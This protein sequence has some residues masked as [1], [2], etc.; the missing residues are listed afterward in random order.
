MA[1]GVLLAVVALAPPARAEGSALRPALR[2][3]LTEDPVS[4]PGNAVIGRDPEDADETRLRGTLAE[5]ITSTAVSVGTAVGYTSNAGPSLERAASAVTSS[6]AEIAHAFQRDG[7]KVS[8]GA[9]YSD[10]R[11]LD[12]AD[13]NEQQ[14]KVTAAYAGKT[15]FGGE[16]TAAAGAERLLD[17]EENVVK[18][19][20]SLGYEWAPALLTP[21][22]QGSIA[23]L[24]YGAIAGEFLEFG[25]QNDRD[26]LTGSV[27]VGLKHAVSSDLTVKAGLGADAKRYDMAVDDFGLRRDNTSVF[28]FLAASYAK[29]GASADLLYAPVFR[30]YRERE[31]APLVAHT[32]AARG[33]MQIAP[34]WKVFAAARAGLEETDFFF[35]KTVRESVVSIG[36]IVTTASGASGGLEVSYTINDY[37][38]L[39]RIDHKI[40]AVVRTKIPLGGNFLLTGEGR[41]LTFR[42]TFADVETDMVMGLVGVVY[43]FSR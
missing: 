22:V 41:Y 4:R 37:V 23:H 12:R 39:P 9:A 42:S 11:Y 27:Q 21:F 34:A 7:N 31:F 36:G 14:V 8:L 32:L 15:G 18:V 26:R 13:V 19:G 3:T 1:S 40:E 29:G 10:R 30:Q 16:V 25:N 2:G 24:D 43:Q 28:P 6:T 38:G 5:E 17:V 20:L 35:A 33:E